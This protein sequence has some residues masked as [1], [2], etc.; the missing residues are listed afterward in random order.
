VIRRIGL[1]GLILVGFLVG[2][3][4]APAREPAS[5]P[6]ASVGSCD[7]DGVT[8]AYTTAYSAPTTS[9]RVTRVTIG[10]I[11]GDCAGGM[12]EVA[13]L[14]TS[15]IIGE[16]GPVAVTPS[17]MQI[18]IDDL[19]RAKDVI[20]VHIAIAPGSDEDEPAGVVPSPD[21]TV[22]PAPPTVPC[23]V[24]LHSATVPA[25][26][27]VGT[28]GEDRLIGTPGPD[29]AC[30]YPGNDIIKGRAGPDH[31]S[32]GQGEDVLMGGKGRDHIHGWKGDDVIR[33]GRGTDRAIGGYGRDRINGG[34]GDDYINGLYDDDHVSGGRG[35]DIVRGGPGDDVVRGGPGVDIINGGRGFDICYAQPGE[36]VRGC[37]EVRRR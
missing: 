16:G 37:E 3:I 30:G 8:V 26:M 23:R 33:A 35:S 32:G 31:L 34:P 25:G 21:P 24:A 6:V 4:V 22:T 15:T 1:T 5:I 11:A 14:G 20:G 13:L 29:S 18:A 12:I 9:Y 27:L 17:S 2:A 7:T 19:P 28:P 36:S 10:D